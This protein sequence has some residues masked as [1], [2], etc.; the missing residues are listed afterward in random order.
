MIPFPFFKVLESVRRRRKILHFTD[1]TVILRRRIF[2][3][4]SLPSTHRKISVSVK[5]QS[6]AHSAF[7]CIFPRLCVRE[8]GVSKHRFYRA[9]CTSHRKLSKLMKMWKK[10][11]SQTCSRRWPR[12]CGGSLGSLRIVAVLVDRHNCKWLIMWLFG[13]AL[14]RVLWNCFRSPVHCKR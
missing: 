3:F 2:R 13:Q 11:P 8:C 7:H 5:M 10:L 4:I 12:W 9:D 1:S 14:H 6:F